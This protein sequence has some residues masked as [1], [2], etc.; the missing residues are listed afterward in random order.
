M[1]QGGYVVGGGGEGE[2]R[3][4]GFQG[5]RQGKVVVVVCVFGGGEEESPGVNAHVCMVRV[6]A[7]HD[8]DDGGRQPLWTA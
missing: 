3:Q 6:C 4:W 1:R 5:G 8:G 2:T 7:L